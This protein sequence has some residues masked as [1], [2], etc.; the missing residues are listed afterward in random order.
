MMNNTPL[1]GSNVNI[2]M[3]ITNNNDDDND[4]THIQSMKMVVNGYDHTLIMTATGWLCCYIGWG[5]CC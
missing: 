2:I 1:D 3:I 4:I 5:I